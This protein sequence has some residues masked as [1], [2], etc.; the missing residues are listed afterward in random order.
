M[1]IAAHKVSGE[2]YR[3]SVRIENESPI[4]EAELVTRDNDCGAPVSRKA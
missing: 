2:T 4:G 1:G 3:L